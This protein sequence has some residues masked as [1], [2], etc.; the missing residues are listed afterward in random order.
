VA[1]RSG[2]NGVLEKFLANELH[3]CDLPVWFQQDVQVSMEVLRRTFPQRLVSRN[4]DVNWPLRSP[5][6]STAD[7]FPWLH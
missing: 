2:Y 1:Q 7:F 5:D 4:G 6:L 3:H